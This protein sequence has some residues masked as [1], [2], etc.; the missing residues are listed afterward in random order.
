MCLEEGFIFCIRVPFELIPM[1][2]I[3]CLDP[4]CCIQPR[5][6]IRGV[7]LHK[8]EQLS[9]WVSL[10]SPGSRSAGL[11]VRCSIRP[12]GS[13]HRVA[14]DGISHAWSRF[15]SSR[16]LASVAAY[17]DAVSRVVPLISLVAPPFVVR[18]I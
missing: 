6:V 3:R 2:E 14:A 8:L 15:A 5:E 12:L 9:T 16:L 13:G 11:P 1:A 4:G 17:G 10:W 7:E 18:G